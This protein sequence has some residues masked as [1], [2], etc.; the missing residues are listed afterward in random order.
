MTD[1]P[2]HRAVPSELCPAWP[3][4]PC[5]DPD[6]ETARL[7]AANLRKAM[8]CQSARSVAASAGVDEKTIR[9][10]LAGASWPELRTIARLE[11]SLG[12]QLY[13]R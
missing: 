12:V 7:L 8:A 6:A 5:F 3:D 2:P 10:V 9:K 4:A 13:P 11:R 1:R